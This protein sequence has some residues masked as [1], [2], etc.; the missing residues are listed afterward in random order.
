MTGHVDAVDASIELSPS[1]TVAVTA[2]LDKKRLVVSE[3]D[4]RDRDRDDIME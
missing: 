1:S 4:R 3:G 2:S